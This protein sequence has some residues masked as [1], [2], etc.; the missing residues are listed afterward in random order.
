M[1]GL[2]RGA[3][4]AKGQ[5][6]GV[7]AAVGGV[8]KLVIEPAKFEEALT[9]ITLAGQG[10]EGKI[11]DIQR[12]IEDLAVSTG[13]PREELGAG[14]E[15]AAKR[16]ATFEEAVQLVTTANKLAATSG[17]EVTDSVTGLSAVMA[18]FEKDISQV[19]KIAAQL[20]ET[21]R[22]LPESASDILTEL[23]KIAPQAR[24]AGL[25]IDDL[26]AAIV[27]AEQGGVRAQDAL[28]ALRTIL[29]ALFS[30]T[31]QAADV[32]ERLGIETG[33]LA[34]EGKSLGEV[35]ARIRRGS[36]SVGVSLR[37]LGLSGESINA[38]LTISENSGKAFGDSLDRISRSS[39]P[40]FEDAFDRVNETLASTLSGF[41]QLSKV[42]ASGFS[43]GFLGDVNG[44]LGDA[45]SR[46][47]ELRLSAEI[48][49][50]EFRRWASQLRP[51]MAAIS[52]FVESIDVS[53]S[54]ARSGVEV[55]IATWE[56]GLV[57]VGLLTA[58]LAED[59]IA[60]Y[61]VTARKIAEV[62]N[63]IQGAFDPSTPALPPSREE[64]DPQISALRIAISRYEDE[65]EELDRKFNAAVEFGARASINQ[66][67][68]TLRALAQAAREEKAE[69]EK[70]RE[71]IPG[72]DT[73]R[74]RNIQN[75]LGLRFL[76]IDFDLISE[77]ASA[78][79]EK[80]LDESQDVVDA[81]EA[82]G[83]GAKKSREEISDLTEKIEELKRAQAIQR[84]EL[85]DGVT[86][87]PIDIVSSSAADSRF[88]L[89]RSQA[90]DLETVGS[91]VETLE[92]R[93]EKLGVAIE[94]A[95]GDEKAIALKRRTDE[96]KTEAEELAVLVEDVRSSTEGAFANAFAG[97]I[98][99]AKTAQEAMRDFGAEVVQQLARIAAQR[100][101]AAIFESFAAADGGTISR[102]GGEPEFR[103]ADGGV[104]PVVPFAEGGPM[105]GTAGGA[106]SKFR[107]PA[108]GL[109][110]KLQDAGM[111]R[112]GSILGLLAEAG[113]PEAV[114]PMQN[115]SVPI[116][117]ER[118]EPVVSLPGGESV[119]VTIKGN[120]V[121]D[122]EARAALVRAV[123]AGGGSQLANLGAG[124]R[125][126]VLRRPTLGVI[127]PGG[128][129][130]AAIPMPQNT[131][132]L[133][134]D[135]DGVAR[136][137]LPK[138]RS[139]PAGEGPGTVP[140]SSEVPLAAESSSAGSALRV[141]PFE[142]G[143]LIES[144]GSRAASG[145]FG[146][147]LDR[148]G[149]GSRSTLGLFAEAGMPEAIVPL[150]RSGSVPLTMKGGEPVVS[151]PGGRSIPIQISGDGIPDSEASAALARAL[152]GGSA[153]LRVPDRGGE[154]LR[155][156]TLREI[157][158]SGPP[159][160]AIPLP[161]GEAVPVLVDSEGVARVDLPQGRSLP[162]AGGGASLR[163]ISTAAP[164]EFAA[165]G[166][167][168]RAFS[169]GGP[170][171]GPV[172]G[173]VVGLP[174][175]RRS[176]SFRAFEGTAQGPGNR[177]NNSWNVQI[178]ALDGPSVERLLA[179]PEGRRAMES[180]MR[181]ARA[182][183]RDF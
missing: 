10:F 26:L 149:A 116:A 12:V 91:E 14:F 29:D 20:F 88:S 24:E 25:G 87:G 117:L 119:P 152:E 104:L 77:T 83:S 102:D 9:R 58:R 142:F 141:R 122:E 118:G 127:S 154:V 153:S 167:F 145:L 57:G 174:Q 182:T 3:R 44:I 165:G 2:S 148:I 163:K 179:T 86:E 65:I 129:S 32:L 33:R 66:R 51:G 177:V 136:V 72:I 106:A 82:I 4:S 138:G 175:A 144:S 68:N 101:A 168:G 56:A 13:T 135:G 178:S 76:N 71:D 125:G 39:V 30:P 43:S 173:A 162:T 183:R 103:A 107:M 133:E 181:N 6:L 94:K 69:L 41:N 115:G 59:T 96:E 150:D 90:S 28:T 63:K 31:G 134:V 49:G 8:Q 159:M 128:P 70:L 110:K 64:L 79:L 81:F 97:F 108:S 99:G 169:A 146:E 62:T 16:V 98:T 147:E 172:G 126:E 151:L 61:N 114:V 92:E 37:E 157:D 112:P 40:E 89:I 27:T 73:T 67:A 85:P 54:I 19:D 137:V 132:P 113:M 74:L 80:Y 47:A 21:T 140:P 48:A 123:E 78:R 53:L 180:A 161:R 121:T 95:F 131:I 75:D 1:E 55:V 11:R 100:A 160:A 5:L 42:L 111:D 35:F 34:L 166:V 18:A 23:G 109:E 164:R 93:F 15:N 84:L 155:G 60:I 46:V 156:P 22:R 52:A 176:S 130:L 38:F 120:G 124:A 105:R 158:P 36:E 45:N 139:L 17:G 50:L 143:G 7:V 170:A 171:G